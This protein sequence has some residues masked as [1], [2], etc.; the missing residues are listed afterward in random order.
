MPEQQKPHPK[1]E[2]TAKDSR[3][4]ARTALQISMDRR[5]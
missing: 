4:Q 1:P 3:E 5:G 2:T